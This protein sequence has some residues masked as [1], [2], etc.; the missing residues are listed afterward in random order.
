[1]SDPRPIGLFDSGVGGLTVLREVRTRVPR[2]ST[3]YLG[4][5]ARAP[6]GSRPDTE[7]VVLSGECLDW[8][9]GQDVKAVVVACSTSSSVAL[10]QLRR[11]STV[12][13][14]GIIAPA[15]AAAAVA[16]RSG[17]I[18]VIATET[19]VRSGSFPRA[20]MRERPDADIRAVGTPALVP[21][22]EA[23][24]LDGTHVAGVVRTSLAPL[25][26][27]G[28]E[29]IDTLLLG[30]THYPLLGAVIADVIGPD[31]TVIDPAAA[32]A[33]ALALLLETD[34]LAAPMDHEPRHLLRTTG[35]P[36]LFGR[37]AQR[38]FGG[39]APAVQSVT[40]G[41]IDRAPSPLVSAGASR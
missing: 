24:E 38:L 39:P 32:I 34:G 3:L 13:V 28:S 1:M 40:L 7:V 37:T 15:A 23:G 19:T 18:G 31:V 17:R 30:C 29:P 11:H 5:N 26:P 20:I 21:L 16:T 10:D 22:V 36:V 9:L 14:L 2:E 4:D 25:S 41:A 33:A 8:L 6:Y 35:D 12:P 27:R